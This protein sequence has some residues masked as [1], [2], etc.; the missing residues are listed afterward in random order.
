MKFKLAMCQMMPATDKDKSMR[1]F[2]RMAEEA[3]SVGA[4]MLVFPE[5]WTCPYMNKWIEAFKEPEGGSFYT[6]MKETAAR[7]GVYIFGGS[8]PEA[9]GGKLYNTCY[10]FDRKGKQI[11]KHRKA[12]MFDIDVPGKIKF[13][14]SAFITPGDKTTIVDT[15]FGKIGVAIC[16]DVRFAEFSRRM[17]LDG[18]QLIVLPAAFNLTTGPA[19]WDLSIKMRAVDNQVFFAGVQPARDPDCEFKAWG[20]SRCCD[21]WGKVLAACDEKPQVIYADIDTDRIEEIRNELPILSGLRPEI[22]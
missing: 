12:H 21:P 11:G 17:A 14:E 1:R 22:Y 3:A 8:M 2:T 6:F 4:D 5:M 10:V 16:F 15:E 13:T 19:H 18:A 7:L 20:N 9:A